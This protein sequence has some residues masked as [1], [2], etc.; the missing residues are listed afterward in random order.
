MSFAVFQQLAPASLVDSCCFVSFT[1]ADADNLVL[2]RGDRLE[3]YN[4]QRRQNRLVF[5]FSVSLFGRPEALISFKPSAGS[6]DHLAI[7]FRR[8]RYLSVLRYEE[9]LGSVQTCGQHLLIAAGDPAAALPEGFQPKLAVDPDNRCLVVRSLPGRLLVFP[10]GRDAAPSGQLSGG[11]P[12]HQ[13]AEQ[14]S[15]LRAPFQIQSW[16]QLRLHHVEDVAFLGGYY[17]PTVACLGQVR[18]S[19]GGCVSETQAT[20]GESSVLVVVLD[21]VQRSTHLVWAS[22]GLPHD[23]FKLV[24]LPPP[25][26]GVLAVSKNSVTYLKEHGSSFCQA[27]NPAG[28]PPETTDASSSLTPKQHVRDESKLDI[29]L[30]SCS[31]V[32]LSPTVVLFSVHPTGRLY[33][34]HFVLSGQDAVTDIVWTSPGQHM[35]AWSIC[36]SCSEDFV[37]LAGTTGSSSLLRVQ[38]TKKKLPSTLQ[39]LKRMRLQKPEGAAQSAPSEKLKELMEIHESLRDVSRFIRSYTF[40]VTDELMTTGP[41]QCL[42]PWCGDSGEEEAEKTGQAALCGTQRF[43]GC[44]GTGSKGDLHIFQRAVPMEALTEFDLPQGVR[45]GAVW[46]LRQAPEEPVI[47]EVS[48]KRSLEDSTVEEAKV[49]AEASAPHRF[50]LVSGAARSM[51]LETTDSIE[52]ISKSTSLDMAS[53]TVGAGNI[54][55]GR[56]VAQ[57]TP[58]R[59]CFMHTSAQGAGSA[60]GPPSVEYPATARAVGASVCDPFIAVRFEDGT[61]R[62][63]VV[64]ES[65]GKVLLVDE[66]GKLPQALASPVVWASLTRSRRSGAALL[67]AVQPS[68]RGTLCV[69]ELGAGAGKPPALVF[70]AGRLADVPPVL[71]GSSATT[72]AEDEVAVR[73]GL[74]SVLDHLRSVTDVAAPLPQQVAKAEQQLGKAAEGTLSNCPVVCAELVDVDAED[75]G[76]TLVLLVQSRPMLVYRAFL[77]KPQATSA[78]FPYSF[79]LVEHDLLGLVQA[80]NPQEP[81][82]PVAALHDAAGQPAG[83]VVVPPHTGVPAL[84]LAA[85][86]NQ[87]FIHPL[88]GDRHR[89]FAALSAPCCGQGFFSLLEPAGQAFLAQVSSPATLESFEEGSGGFDLRQAIPVARHP[90]QRRPQCLA[91]KPD[92]GLLGIAVS[93]MVI[94]SPDVPAGPGIDEDPL[95]E[96]WSIIRE[97]PVTN[98]EAPAMPRLQPRYEL[99]LENAKELSQL[100]RYRFTFDTE[101]AVLSLAWVNIPGFP[102]PSLAV[103]TGVNAGEDLTCRGRLLLF[104]TKDREPGILPP[105]YQRSLK[106]PVTLVGQWGNSYFLHSEGFKLYV[107]KWENSSFNKIAFFDGGMCMTA[108]SNIKNFMLFGDLRKGVD[109][110]QWKEEAS[111]GTRTLRRLSRSPPST[112][113]TVLACEFVVHQK[114]LGLVALDHKGSAHLFQYTPHSDGREGD[115]LLRSCATFAMGS[116][117]RAALRLQIETGI[118]SLFM[119]AGSGELSC[120]R[121]IDDQAYRTITTL[122]GMLF[123]RLP[124]RCGLNPR[125]FRSH[126]GPPSLVAPRKNIEDAVLLRQF[127]FLSTPLQTSI[128]EK[129]RLPVPALMKAVAPYASSMM[130][131]LR[132]ASP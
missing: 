6:P 31:T 65:G 61:L 36:R 86:R 96:D 21:L 64:Q 71:R 5:A 126:E 20:Q 56:M 38:Q 110:C 28:L 119:A 63:F 84:W 73:A 129:M 93:E 45:F 7:V 10:A 107:E 85:R 34:A 70:R 72:G 16:S 90:L 106:W 12:F 46:S 76:P 35:P 108:M 102:Q 41:L 37:F 17:Q 109:F 104:S 115:Q 50:V 62:L 51:L 128:A 120:I 127:A 77:Q 55:Q 79:A 123:T 75:E 105:V 69:V 98:K 42:Q 57:L 58:E 100:G 26:S 68:N 14:P 8:A 44:G 97:P 80:P 1:S 39:P 89:G 83:A 67:L 131:A 13:D 54:L 53:A 27:L 118:Q 48:R 82:R 33:L 32:V 66:T 4:L 18:P 11:L 87:L 112:P 122:L 47:A 91:T 92:Q 81:Y 101:E 25:I 19:W 99:W 24:P 60:S 49:M 103:G 78:R 130:F 132:P 59:V 124:F 15:G 94:E 95:S 2:T 88:P 23:L 22:H 125:A 117:V 9:E 113:M 52:E 3:V 29:L 111:T 116:P 43:V 114:S 74:D 121:P 40:E 30:A